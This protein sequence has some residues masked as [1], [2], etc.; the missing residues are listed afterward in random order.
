[1]I[2][3]FVMANLFKERITVRPSCLS[4]SADCCD[5]P[6]KDLR[7]ALPDGQV[8]PGGRIPVA[9][10]DDADFKSLMEEV[11]MDVMKKQHLKSIIG[12]QPAD[13]QTRDTISNARRRMRNWHRIHHVHTDRAR[14]TMKCTTNHNLRPGD[15][16]HDV[17]CVECKTSKAAADVPRKKFHPTTKSLEDEYTAG[18]AFVLDSA[19]IGELGIHG[20]KYVIVFCDVISNTSRQIFV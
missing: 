18:E 14:R 4:S 16:E 2:D 15:L 3:E 19:H 8:L 5:K 10:P 6:A 7:F 13:K 20:Y 17:P 12:R 1:M 11:S 9:N